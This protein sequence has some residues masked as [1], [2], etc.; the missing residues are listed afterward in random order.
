MTLVYSGHWG[1]P[2]RG[3]HGS[4]RA[5]CPMFYFVGPLSAIRKLIFRYFA[6]QEKNRQNATSNAAIREISLENAK[7]S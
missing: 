3:A 4:Y 7:K 5:S 1:E 2:V 6:E